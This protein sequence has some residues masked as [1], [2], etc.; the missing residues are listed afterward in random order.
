MRLPIFFI[1]LSI[2]S[3]NTVKA[4]HNAALDLIY[5]YT[6]TPNEYK[7]SLKFYYDCTSSTSLGSTL[8]IDYDSDLKGSS[9]TLSLSLISGPLEVDQPCLPGPTNCQ[10]PNSP[11]I[12][13]YEY[14]Y[15]GT[16]TL[17]SKSTDWVIS[18]TSCCR[19]AA[20]STLTNPSSQDFYVS[21][22]INNTDAPENSSPYFQALPV[23]QLCAGNHYDLSQMAAEKDGDSLRYT[24]ME[25]EGGP[26]PG[27]SL[28]SSYIS[29]YTPDYP[30]SSSSGFTIDS[31]NGNLAFTP[32]LEQMAVA[33]ILVEEFRFD[34]VS[35]VWEKIGSIKRD[36]EMIIIGDCLDDSKQYYLTVSPDPNNPDSLVEAACMDTLITIYTSD[37]V[38]CGSIAT[39][40][41]DFRMLNPNGYPIPVVAANAVNC[42]AGYTNEIQLHLASPMNQNGTYYIWTKKGYDQNSLITFCGFQLAEFDTLTIYVDS[43]PDL[44]IDL[45]NVT[46]VN[47]DSI[48]MKWNLPT[49]AYPMVDW[50]VIFKQYNIYRSLLPNGFYSYLG[51]TYGINDTAFTDNTVDV[52]TT[53]YDYNIKVELSN[54]YTSPSSDSIQSILLTCGQNTIDSTKIDLAWTEYWG[55]TS[56]TYEIYHATTNGSWT[57]MGITN[58]TN[59]SFDKPVDANDYKVKVTT[60][61]QLNS[62]ESLIS[63][64]NWCEYN[65]PLYKVV[66]PNVF[67]PN[68]DGKN[69]FLEFDNLEQY[70]NTQLNIY[71]RWGRRVYQSDNYKNDWDGAK[72]TGGTYYYIL[73]FTDGTIKTGTITLLK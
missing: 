53:A 29:P 27:V 4:S 50:T 2:L 33:C 65:V 5:E 23:P 26:Y 55:W 71:N 12:G 10:D 16:L 41:S 51:S 34:T 17:P 14:V 64:S 47:N 35:L 36:M 39:D 15:E 72:L 66:I 31:T 42:Y 1:L 70:K 73:E 7:V 25:A 22:L 8:T 24:L 43:C 62:S 69:D 11:Y 45:R 6:G 48:A 19:N 32:N 68:G 49:N 57:L 20:L 18:Y 46:V 3:F 52:Q 60:S 13:I 40:G 58:N 38:Q 21:A 61:Y 44:K 30:I 67:S 9:G 56:P 63:E 37:S 59:Y 28:L 54:K